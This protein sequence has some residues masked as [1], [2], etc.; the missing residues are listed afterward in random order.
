MLPHGHWGPMPPPLHLNDSTYIQLVAATEKIVKRLLVSENY[1]SVTNFIALYDAYEKARQGTPLQ[2][3]YRNFV[4]VCRPHANTCVGLALELIRR[5]QCLERRFPGLCAATGM[6]SCEESAP[7]VMRDTHMS[8][9]PYELMAPD[10][11]HVMVGVQISLNGRRGVLIGDPGYH[12]GRIVTIMVDGEY[13]HTGWFNQVLKGYYRKNFDYAFCDHNLNYIIWR[14]EDYRNQDYHFSNSLIYAS[15]PFCDGICITEKRNLVY[16]LKSLVARS[17]TGMVKAGV[18]FCLC[19]YFN[20]AQITVFYSK[21]EEEEG[22]IKTQNVK[23]KYY[24]KVFK[25]DE[26]LHESILK[27]VRICNQQLHFPEGKLLTIIQRLAAVL[28]DEPFVRQC[29]ELNAYIGQCSI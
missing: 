22:E 23:K 13:P 14:E 9:G 27:H 20:R 6:L 19:P 18:V 24:L 3:L 5:W 17:P 25:D 1:D 16:R 10:K 28:S 21:Q 7:G 26:K 4:P 12:V 29:I 8:Q 2:E 11:E 15:R